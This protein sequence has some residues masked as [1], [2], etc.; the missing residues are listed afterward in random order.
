MTLKERIVAFARLGE[1][2]LQATSEEGIQHSSLGKAARQSY[3]SNN[4]LTEE[5]CQTALKGI[6][7]MLKAE[8]LENWTGRYPQIKQ[9][10]AVACVLAGNIPAVGFH[11]FLCVLLSGHTF[12]GKI[13]SKDSFLLPCLAK[14]LIEFEPRFESKIF[15]TEHILGKEYPFDAVIA[16]GSNNSSRYFQ[17]YFAQ[18]P[19]IIR[20]GKSSV[21]VLSGQESA[22]EWKALA[23]D[24][25]QYFGLGCRNVS[26]LYIPQELELQEIFVHFEHYQSLYQHHKYANNVDY[27]RSIMLVNKIPFFD[28]GFALFTENRQLLSPISVIHYERY[29]DLT[30][31]MEDLKQQSDQIQC[32]VSSIPDW[33][34]IP[35]GKAQTPEL[36]D[37]ADH[38]DTFDFLVN[39]SL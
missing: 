6:A 11:D 39:L 27:N 16:T 36:D 14:L 32:V 20:N 26:K 8:E 38:I 15:F 33:K 3:L 2:I 24:L 19:H 31:V 10:C 13:S 25:F 34:A 9:S 37:Y 1:L 21:A 4:W 30:Q 18:Y 12:V 22:A 28:L 23:D 7:H 35:L 29:A 17:Q 5:N